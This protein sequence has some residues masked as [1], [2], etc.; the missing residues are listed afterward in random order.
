MSRGLQRE[1]NTKLLA[2]LDCERNAAIDGLRH[3]I[4][5]ETLTARFRT[6][7]RLIF[8]MAPVSIRFAR[9]KHR[10][11]HLEA[12]LSADEHPVESNIDGLA[13]FANATID[14][15][16]SLEDLFRDVDSALNLW[17]KGTEP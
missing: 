1:L 16:G 13:S 9:V 2:A 5:V 14:N 8:L 4:D 17:R 10:F 3:Q 12:F 11:S 15:V 7:F 6:S